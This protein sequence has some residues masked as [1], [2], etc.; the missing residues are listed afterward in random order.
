MLQD[1]SE[2]FRKSLGL[3][4][5]TM[6]GFGS[7]FGSGWLFA[8]PHVAD[9]AGPASIVSWFTGGVA[10]LLI[11]LVYCELG[12]SLP[13]AGGV[14]HYPERSH[15]PAAAFVMGLITTIAF[16]SL[17][18]IE[19][20]A[21]R[22]YAGAWITGLN[23]NAAGD[24]TWL[25]WGLQ[26][27]VLL[28]LFALNRSGMSRFALANNVI[29]LFKFLV[30]LAVIILLF[31]H[32]D[33]DNF[34]AQGFAPFGAQ[35]IETAVSTGGIIFAYL[36]LTPILSVA[37]EVKNPQRTIPIALIA[38]VVLSTLV[39]VLLQT[40]FIGSL[41]AALMHDGWG[42][43]GGHLPLPF[44][45]IALLLGLGGLAIV[46][47]L[48]AILSPTGTGNVYMS[49]A[50]RVIYAWSRAGVFFPI[51][52]QVNAKTGVPDPA[53]E[54]TF[55]LALFWTLP[56]PSWQALISVVSSALMLSY[57]FAPL[58]AAALRRSQPALPRPFRLRGFD[59]FSPVSFV[60]AS[61]IVVWTGWTTLS[62]LLPFVIV[63][64]GAFMLFCKRNDNAIRSVLWMPGYLIGL[65]V[66]SWLGPF[67]GRAVL[68]TL[69][70]DLGV[71]VLSLVIHEWAARTAL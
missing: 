70:T 23:R 43:I 69:A 6:I 33:A 25:G 47:V 20:V 18:A 64:A 48:D 63:I 42:A 30:P 54:L 60:I 34:T 55:G 5:L 26:A 39:Y 59:F 41:P 27:V 3:L 8:A 61:L 62:W 40:A 53:L 17:I 11:G 32:F 37:S 52:K 22:Q 51:F 12:A 1:D 24:P 7:V 31:M 46:V 28:G 57:A 21:A 36:G 58:C 10:V 66:F 15:G 71:G 29:T 56:F 49:A 67:G 50:P 19:I 14:V 13:K 4:D 16:T 38:S 45:D 68:D 9:I 65:L 2:G 35:G 44:H